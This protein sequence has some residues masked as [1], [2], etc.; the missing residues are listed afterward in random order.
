MSPVPLICWKQR[1]PIGTRAENLKFPAPIILVPTKFL[2]ALPN[3]P[4]VQFRE[5]TTF[6]RRSLY[7]ASKGS[8]DYLV[9]AWHETYG[10]PVALTNCSNNYGPYHFP[11]KLV[12]VYILNALA[13][14]RPPIYVNGSNIRD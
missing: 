4:A 14:K 1:D 12:L 3:D 11:K 8:S 9:R 13:G 2:E 6:D 10:L 7:S 5:E